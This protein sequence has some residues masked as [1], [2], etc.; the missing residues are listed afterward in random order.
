[1]RSVV[2]GFVSRWSRTVGDSAQHEWGGFFVC[3]FCL[4]FAG[5]LGSRVFVI[6]PACISGRNFHRDVYSS[7]NSP[8]PDFSTFMMVPLV[9]PRVARKRACF[10]RSAGVVAGSPYFL[11][12]TSW[13]RVSSVLFNSAPA[14]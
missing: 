9:K 13:A 1:M 4:L 12:Q 14:S 8:S 6:R 3:V 2:R 5:G 10:A 11:L 7:I